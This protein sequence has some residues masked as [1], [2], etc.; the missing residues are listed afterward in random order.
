MLSEV[1]FYD[2]SGKCEKVLSGEKLSK[3]YWKKLNCS[4]TSCT[5]MKFGNGK[6]FNK[7]KL[8]EEFDYYLDEPFEIYALE[9]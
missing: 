1:R 8:L 9:E 2:S 6:R 5:P 4:Q 7:K 3:D